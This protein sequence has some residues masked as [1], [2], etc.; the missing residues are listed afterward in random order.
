[1][2]KNLTYKKKT[3]YLL[4][5][6]A[7]FLLLSYQLSISNTFEAR[8][9]CKTYEEQLKFIEDAPQKIA[10]IESQLAQ[11]ENRIGK[12]TVAQGDFQKLLLEKVS[13]YCQL[14]NLILRE[15]PETNSFSRQEYLVETNVVV[16]E[17]PFIKLLKLVYE[18]E[19][20][21]RI[22]KVV[23]LQFSAKKDLKT[24]VLRLSATIY[25]QNINK[26]KL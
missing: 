12:N 13:K 2:F 5:G 14:N 20:K 24:N 10:I 7:V 8:S 4:I 1:M 6:F 19:Q 21:S 16:V 11:I 9:E 23:A 18:L 3:R 17:G 25:F 22:G 26:Q 15:F